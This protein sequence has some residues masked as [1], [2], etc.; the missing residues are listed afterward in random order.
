[1]VNELTADD[2]WAI[3]ETLSWHGHLFDRGELDR[4]GEIFTP[5]VVYDLS[6]AGVGVFEGIDAI[7]DGA[8]RLG[9][10]NPIA[11]HV[12]N[13]V[14]TSVDG[15][16]VTTQSK[17]FMIMADGSPASVT[18]QDTLRRQPGG[19]RISRRVIVPQRAPLGAPSA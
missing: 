9:P 17:G 11:H 13:I 4:L 2:R 10:G 18:H 5:D 12:T 3:A 7:R 6:G 19:W 8:R 15:D 16:L 14:I 1:M